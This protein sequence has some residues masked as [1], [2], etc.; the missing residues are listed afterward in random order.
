MP[1]GRGHCHRSFRSIVLYC[2][3]AL[4]STRDDTSVLIKNPG[5]SPRRPFGVLPDIS[6]ATGVHD[7]KS[8]SG[9][10]SS[11]SVTLF[12]T[13][14]VEVQ[15]ITNACVNT[16]QGVGQDFFQRRRPSCEGAAS[17][18]KGGVWWRGTQSRR[19]NHSLGCAIFLEVQ[20]AFCQWGKIKCSDR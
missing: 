16:G 2:R 1:V 10:C 15:L 7:D 8:S 19:R 14:I 20:V 13:R 5:I 12:S 11:G 9:T 18:K 17:A 3:R 4:I 6:V